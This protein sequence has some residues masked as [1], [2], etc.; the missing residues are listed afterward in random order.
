MFHQFKRD[1]SRMALPQRYDD[2]AQGKERHSKNRQQ[3]SGQAY[4]NT[5]VVIHEAE[6]VL[7]STRSSDW[8]SGIVTFSQVKQ[9]WYLPQGSPSVRIAFQCRVFAM[10]E[11]RSVSWIL[12]DL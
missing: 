6:E 5:L 2:P 7:E 1:N 8:H 3:D 12:L 11:H 4:H 9:R 10:C